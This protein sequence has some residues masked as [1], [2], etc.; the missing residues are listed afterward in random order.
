[1]GADAMLKYKMP[2]RPLLPLSVSALVVLIGCSREQEPTSR[3][4]E[5]S[6]KPTSV[7][8]AKVERLDLAQE[9]QLAAEFRPYQEIGVHAKVPG[10]L[11]SISVD[12][13]DRVVA[14]QLLATLEAP[15][16]S[17]Q[18]LQAAAVEKRSELDVVRAQGEVRRAEAARNLRKISY[19]R[20]AAVAKAKPE[21]I[22]QAEIEDAQGRLHESEAQLA[23]AQAA[24]AAVEQ[25]VHV[26]GASRGQVN[27]MMRYLRI[28]A[29]F[30]G[31]ITKRYADLGAMVP[32]G[33]SSSTIPV[34]RLSQVDKL[35]LVVPVPESIVPRVRIGA[36]VEVR[37]DTLGRVFQGKVTRLT[38][39]LETSTRTME[40]E[41]D[42]PNPEG[43]LNP[44]MYAYANLLLSQRH[45]AL[46][47]PVQALTGS[48]TGTEAAGRRSVL[49]VGENQTVDS[50]VIHIG[51]ETPD[52]VEVLDGLQEGDLVI[53]AGTSLKQG[54]KVTPRVMTFASF[55]AH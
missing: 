55:E 52:R 48:V 10:Y 32:A 45:Q 39:R 15:E 6:E 41:I 29:P 49:V 20:L 14:G 31:V 2:T 7:N 40:T 17:E 33:T 27:T 21:L 8:V 47:L 50:R 51:L 54:Q 28:T 19:E 1:M 26:A 5:I 42:V 34:V 16:W 13:G 44:G 11:K 12:V 23:T 35:R 53:V 43:V 18:L 22:A 46:A 9:L 4:Q 25:Q 30:S 37:V 38:G 36:P 3:V 24:L